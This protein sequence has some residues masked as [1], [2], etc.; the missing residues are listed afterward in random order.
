MIQ[1]LTVKEMKE[2]Y[3]DIEWVLSYNQNSVIGINSKTGDKYTMEGS[4]IAKGVYNPKPYDK[5]N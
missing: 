2:K 5:S 1:E 3:P 4:E